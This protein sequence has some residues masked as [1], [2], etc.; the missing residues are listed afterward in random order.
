MKCALCLFEFDEKSALRACAGCF[1]LGGCK[2]IKCPK[3]GYEV[4]PE[5][6]WLKRLN[7][8]LRKGIKK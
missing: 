1:K 7:K 3:C 2:M 6:G 4:P 8:M 5:P